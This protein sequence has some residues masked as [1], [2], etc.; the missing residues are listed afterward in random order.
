MTWCRLGT[1]FFRLFMRQVCTPCST[2]TGLLFS[3]PSPFPCALQY[4]HLFFAQGKFLC[5]LKSPTHGII[6]V[7]NA[8]SHSS[9]P[10]KVL[11]TTKPRLKYH[12]FREA[13]HSPLCWLG[14][15]WHALYF[16][17]SAI[18]E[19]NDV[20]LWVCTCVWSFI[21][22]SPSLHFQPTC[23][24]KVSFLKAGYYFPL[25]RIQSLCVFLIGEVL[26]YLHLKFHFFNR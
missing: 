9:S 20:V 7:R 3:P 14:T 12:F 19:F 25:K 4:Q 1:I 16:L 17:P 18:C 11:L 24:L 2:H 26:I 21:Y 6:S 22:L 10:T 15:L 13:F 8:P 23:V 5:I